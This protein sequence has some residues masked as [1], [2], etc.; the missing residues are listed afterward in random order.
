MAGV[1][2]AGPH[3]PYQELSSKGTKGLLCTWLSVGTS[4]PQLTVFPALGTSVGTYRCI[5]THFS[6]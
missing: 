2:T 4:A 1:L 3:Y 6:G 5:I